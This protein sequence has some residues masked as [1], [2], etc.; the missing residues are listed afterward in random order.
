MIMSVVY[1][2]APLFTGLRLRSNYIPGIPHM[3]FVAVLPQKLRVLAGHE[4][5]PQSSEHV[6]LGL[7]KLLECLASIINI[8]THIYIY[9]YLYTCTYI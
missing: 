9:I 8:R 7:H 1:V 6:R 5:V 2:Y 4:V 3:S